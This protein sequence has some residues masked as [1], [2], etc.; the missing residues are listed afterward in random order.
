MEYLY[1]LNVSVPM[2]QIAILLVLSTISLL[3]GRVKLALLVNY[4]FTVY[5]GYFSNKDFF[6]NLTG[7]PEYFVYIYFGFGIGVVVLAMIGF[8]SQSTS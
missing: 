5:W 7:F 1:S 4:L 3:Y 2:S 8:L 6:T